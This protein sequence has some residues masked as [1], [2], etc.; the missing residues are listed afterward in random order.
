MSRTDWLDLAFGAL[1]ALNDSPTGLQSRQGTL[2][3]EIAAALAALRPP[4]LKK[5]LTVGDVEQQLRTISELVAL[6]TLMVD[7]SQQLTELDPEQLAR[8]A[9]SIPIRR[10]SYASPLEIGL[11]VTSGAVAT[12]TVL[13]VLIYGIKKLQGIRLELRTHKAALR[14][15][16]LEAEER[17]EE[18]EAKRRSAGWANVIDSHLPSD[19]S[20]LYSQSA[21]LSDEELG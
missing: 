5:G 16:F 1:E 17:V 3:H 13:E 15:R 14:A 20:S 21:V 4:L 19:Q 12:R 18:L 7:S 6:A 2:L 10:I 11:A 8:D 9:E